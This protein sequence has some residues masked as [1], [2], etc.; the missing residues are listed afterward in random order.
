VLAP[1][2]VLDVTHDATGRRLW[3]VPV[4]IGARIDLH[5]TNS[6]FNAPTT[7]RFVVEDRMLRLVEINS[8]REAVLLHAGLEGPYEQ[9]AG[10]FAA[11]R[12][13]PAV[14]ELTI[15]I[16]QTG[17]QRLD[18]NGRELPLYRIGTGEAARVRLSRVPRALILA[19]RPQAL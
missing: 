4:G 3:R 5:Y 7:D 13:G 2:T 10:R 16:G 9:R 17:Q 14:A 15:R 6:L 1:V 12:P 8:T 11:T 18:V 19:A